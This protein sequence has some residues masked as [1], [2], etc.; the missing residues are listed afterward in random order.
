MDKAKP[1]AKSP[2][3]GGGASADLEKAVMKDPVVK[4]AIRHSGDEP[5]PGRVAQQKAEWSETSLRTEGQRAVSALWE[6]TQMRL[7]L[8]TVSGFMLAHVFVVVAVG[9][10]LFLNWEALSDV[11][12][13]LAALVAILTG[14]LGAIASM[15]SLVIAAYFHRTNSSRIGGVGKDYEGR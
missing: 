14:S 15:A 9:G 13:A 3:S 10:V 11:P 4:A 6:G 8:L 12:A 1:A 2:A 7:A 5:S